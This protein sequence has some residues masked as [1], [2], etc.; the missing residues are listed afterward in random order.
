MVVSVFITLVISKVFSYSSL[1]IYHYITPLFP[2][3]S[4]E[5]RVAPVNNQCNPSEVR[6]GVDIL[7]TPSTKKRDAAFRTLRVYPLALSERERTLQ[8]MQ[9]ETCFSQ[10][11]GDAIRYFTPN[12]V[13]MAVQSPG[14]RTDIPGPLVA[15]PATVNP[16]RQ[17]PDRWVRLYGC[18]IPLSGR[19]R[20]H[21]AFRSAV[22]G[23]V[24][25]RH[26]LVTSRNIL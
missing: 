5:S 8:Q 17:F 24:E 26:M 3:G 19:E 23:R 14:C 22:F 20:K 15:S 21:L 10:H 18:S 16:R 9:R 25:S 1:Y 13:K 12:Q 11:E 6:P 2:T 4:R 7:H